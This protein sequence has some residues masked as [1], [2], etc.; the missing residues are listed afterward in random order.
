MIWSFCLF[1]FF[2]FV[3]FSVVMSDKNHKIVTLKRSCISVDHRNNTLIIHLKP[4]VCAGMS[5][6]YH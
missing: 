1:I 6:V 2:L 4:A 3:F 5:A